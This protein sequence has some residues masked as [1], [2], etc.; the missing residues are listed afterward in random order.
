MLPNSVKYT[1]SPTAMVEDEIR[2]PLATSRGATA[3][4]VVDSTGAANAPSTPLY[5]AQSEI[6]T[7]ASASSATN[8]FSIDALYYSAITIQYTSVGSGN[9]VTYE[10]SN[11]NATWLAVLVN[12]GENAAST[13]NT[14]FTV[15]A[16]HE[17][18]VP[19]K[20]RYFRARISTYGSGTVTAYY[21]LKSGPEPMS[22]TIRSGGAAYGTGYTFGAIPLTQAG[23]TPS[24]ARIMSA[25][26]TN[27]TS[28]K[29][30]AG[31][32]YNVNLYNSGTLAFI[33][34]Y[35]KA[36]SPTVG[37]DTPVATYAIPASGRC[38]FSIPLGLMF[39]TGIAY[40]ITG[41]VADSDTT[42]VTLNQVTGTFIYA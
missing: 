40:A 35:N 12:R 26:S 41:G 31:Q 37:S 32:V 1:A 24:T 39:T 28:T 15:T 36:S 33:K 18:F 11:D 2:H 7:N 22:T 25:A 38:D 20:F 3:V 8:I 16:S 29:A 9:T 30:S 27:G 19:L 13:A 6:S 17:I 42:A 23:S 4:G 21:A 5:V 10:G 14:A 34:F